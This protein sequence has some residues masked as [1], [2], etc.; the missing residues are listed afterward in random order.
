[1]E[2]CL[3]IYNYGCT[4]FIYC[5][6]NIIYLY[7]MFVYYMYTLLFLNYFIVYVRVYC[8]K[9]ENANN[10]NF[11]VKKIFKKNQLF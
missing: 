5:I 6:N 2:F 3:P 11:K 10:N 7:Y 1:M 4:T 8:L 9:Y